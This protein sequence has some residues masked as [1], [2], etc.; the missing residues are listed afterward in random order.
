MVATGSS[1][2]LPPVEITKMVYSKQAKTAAIILNFGA[3][4]RLFFYTPFRVT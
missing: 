3:N 4:I 2:G 1:N